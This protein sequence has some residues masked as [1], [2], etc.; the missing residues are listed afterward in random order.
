MGELLDTVENQGPSAPKGKDAS[1]A[2]LFR[3]ACADD[4]TVP[5]GRWTLPS[6]ALIGRS[7]VPFAIER[8]GQLR[9][10][11][12]DPYASSRHAR[13]GRAAGAWL[14]HDEGSTNGTLVNGERVAPGA[15]RALRE[16][17][18]LEV[19]HTFFLFR[20]GAQVPGPLKAI[21]PD[22]GRGTLCPEW[23]RQLERVE[24]LARTAHPVLLQGESGAGKDVL[25]RH[26]HAASGRRGKLVSINCAALAENLLEDELFGHTQG[27][28][29]GAQGER[30]GL[31]RAADQGT[32]FLDEVGDMPAGLQSRL[33]R[34]LEDG[35]V[36]PLGSEKEIRVDV[37]VL[38]A[39][40]MDLR[41]LVE[42]Q[43]FRHD[44]HARLGLTPIRIPALR[45]R[46]EDL[47]QL[48][49]GMLRE[50]PPPPIRFT[51]EALRRVL[52]HTW[53]LNA[54][55]LRQALLT[56]RDLAATGDEKPTVID[57]EHL[58]PAL[59]EGA[60]DAVEAPGR[61]GEADPEDD[62]GPARPARPLSPEDQEL[63]DRL[64]ESLRRTGGN[65]AA[66]ARDLGRART[67]VQRW[68][69][70]FGVDLD[71]IRRGEA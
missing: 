70:R 8:E 33:L 69:A 18:L 1:G 38:A 14:V 31:F 71:A 65:T 66:T 61:A 62:A 12:A 57:L 40:H 58:P 34:V 32:L 42:R 63:R 35:R 51:L 68:I 4:L 52:L 64:V 53:P 45:E 10:G 39:S 19:G 24:K 17:D 59:L 23:E 37:R 21:D 11:V 28:Y 43:K 46:R 16:G 36:R 50:A 44:L 48:V 29:S 60:G 49:R 54:R 41:A 22:G 25:A 2:L 56:A 27:A 55:E 5:S 9:I 47:G 26:I 67:Q 6:D 15:P 30:L 7:A 3:L 20:A 13:L